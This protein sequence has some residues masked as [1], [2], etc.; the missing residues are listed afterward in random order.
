MKN[1]D[2]N[3]IDLKKKIDLLEEE[4]THLDLANYNLRQQDKTHKYNLLKLKKIQRLTSTGDWELDQVSGVFNCSDE[5]GEMLETPLDY[6]TSWD[7]FIQFVHPSESTAVNEALHLSTTQR[8]DFEIEHRLVLRGGGVKFVK[9]YCKSFFTPNGKIMSSIG[10]IQDITA[11]KKEEQEKKMLIQ[12]LQTTL[13]EMKTLKGIIPICMYCK[14][15][16]DDKGAWNQLERFITEH[17]EAQ[18]SH[19]VCDECLDKYHPEEDI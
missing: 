13:E 2:T 9:H 6:L 10:H 17:S 12:E 16:R 18:F 19:G 1:T 5:L 15:I 3:I 8:L 7:D 14:G 4:I 11:R